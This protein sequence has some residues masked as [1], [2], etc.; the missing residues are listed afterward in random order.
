MSV[1]SVFVFL[2]LAVGI[3]RG[4]G[5]ISGFYIDGKYYPGFS[6]YFDIV[7]NET[8]LPP[9]RIAYSIA[10]NWPVYD[11]LSS[12]ITCSFNPLPDPP[13]L[14]APA[15]PGSDVTMI[16]TE[17]PNNHF[18]TIQTYMASCGTSCTSPTF[19]VSIAPFFKIAEDGLRSDGTWAS[20][21]FLANNSTWTFKVPTD[22]KDGYYVVRHEMISLHAVEKYGAELYPQ[23][24]Q[25]QIVGGTGTRE[26]DGVRFPG[27]YAQ[28]DPGLTYNRTTDAGTPYVFPGPSLYNA[29]S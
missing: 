5:F 21:E 28:K 13:S 3:V 16:Y 25:I 27:A 17:W 2:S 23:C 8:V 24:F 22:L 14:V 1:I 15:R 20:D 7:G 9:S 19:N 4:H 26:P 29:P 10:D 6:P 12:N 11:V 18:G